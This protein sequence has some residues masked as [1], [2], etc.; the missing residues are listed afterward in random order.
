M[1]KKQLTIQEI[2]AKKELFLEAIKKSAE[3]Q[4]NGR[5]SATTN[6]LTEI[7]ELIKIALS[8]QIPFEQ[9]RKDIEAVYSF[10]VS[11]QTLRSFCKATLNYESKPK[12]K[13]TDIFSNSQTI[14]EQKISNQNIKSDKDLM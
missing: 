8:K 1:S 5:I 4:T 6:F 11:S 14:K 10:K 2:A 7:K 3:N 9:I 13:K 12:S